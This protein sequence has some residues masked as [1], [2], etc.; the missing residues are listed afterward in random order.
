MYYGG[1]TFSEAW[2]LPVA[3]RKWFIE[4]ILK[5]LKGKSENDSPPTKAL[6]AN[7][8]QTRAMQGMTRTSSPSRLR[9]FT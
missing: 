3:Y 8:E 6:H 5:E 1:F 9:R 2:K 4:R 7:D